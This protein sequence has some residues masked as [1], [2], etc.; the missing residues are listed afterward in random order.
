MTDLKKLEQNMAMYRR[1]NIREY[2]S[3]NEDHQLECERLGELRKNLL[4]KDIL[5]K[6]KGDVIL[7]ETKKAE[8]DK[9]ICMEFRGAIGKK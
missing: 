3:F 1:K 5:L 8:V 4:I 6:F 2:T 9:Y 7:Q